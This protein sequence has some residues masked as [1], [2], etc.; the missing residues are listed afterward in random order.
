MT[1]EPF[2]LDGFET[3]EHSQFAP[4]HLNLLVGADSFFV[5]GLTESELRRKGSMTA[6]QK[7]TREKLES[8]HGRPD[9]KAIEKSVTDL[10]R[11]FLPRRVPVTLRSDEHRAYPRA[12]RAIQD[13]HD[14]K[15]EVTSSKAPRTRYN[16]LFAVNLTDLL[17]RHGSANHKR[18]TIAFSKRRQAVVERGWMFVIWR[19]FLKSRSEN[20]RNAPPAVELGVVP[21]KPTLAELLARRLFPTHVDLPGPLHAHY[22]RR[23]VTRYLDPQR[24][25]DLKYAF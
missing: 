6:E 7:K 13:T 11:I 2:V 1:H 23:I 8:K 14:V 22:W 20:K 10:L 18:E 12:L 19:N 5:H 4:M 17:L 3:F 16:P 25:H 9:P 21:R 24:I 15:H